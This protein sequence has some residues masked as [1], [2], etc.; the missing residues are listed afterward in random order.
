MIK[1]K[2]F[3]T[4]NFDSNE[5][6]FMY[7]WLQELNDY[8][9]ID[10]IDVNPPSYE[11]NEEVSFEFKKDIQMKTKVKQKII[12]KKLLLR[13]VYTPDYIVKFNEKLLNILYVDLTDNKNIDNLDVPFFLLGKNNLIYQNNKL[14]KES[15]IID[16]K[17]EYTR[18]L[19][20]SITF[21]DRQAMMYN[22]YK[23]YV[24]KCIPH[25]RKDCLFRN[26]FVP[27]DI[28]AELTYV[29]DLKNLKV[30]A[31]DSKIKYPIKNIEEWLKLKNLL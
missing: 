19:N 1:T 21:P 14:E 20:T 11:I 27:K 31:G 28:Q 8:N 30:K 15:I 25:G 16:V 24:N 26:T 23:V 29:K 9:L 22:R 4:K 12:K 13:K 2:K 3:A 7:N 10:W 17:G 18:N 6:R 5:E